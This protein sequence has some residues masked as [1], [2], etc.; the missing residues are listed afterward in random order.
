MKTRGSKRTRSVMGMFIAVV[1][2]VLTVEGSME[3]FIVAEAAEYGSG[4]VNLAEGKSG[5]ASS[6]Q[7][8][9]STVG[10]RKV[11]Y[12]TD[13]N[14]SSY[15]ILH[16]EDTDPWVYA[17]LESEYSVNKV[18]VYQ[19]ADS[20]YPN[21]YA[22]AFT[23]E[24]SSDLNGSWKTAAEYTQGTAGKNT[25]TFDPVTARYIRIRVKEKFADYASFLELMVYETDESS[26]PEE[27]TDPM[28]ILFIGN[29][30]TYYNDVAGKVKDL[31]AADGQEIETETLI[32]LGKSLTYHSTLPETE[33]TIL[34]GDFDYVVL[35]D[36]ASNFDGS[37][38][39]TGAEAI[40]QWIAQADAKTVFY[41]PW[42][43]EN[44]LE[45]TQS[46]FTESYITAAKSLGAQLAPAGEVWYEFYFDYGYNW[47]SDN[48]H[49]NN[50]GSLVSA[51][52]IFYTITGKT[53]PLT[54][55]SADN[56]V[57]KNNVDAALMNLIQQRC[58]SYAA[59]YQDLDNIQDPGEKPQLPES[60]QGT[61]P[62]IEASPE[63]NPYMQRVSAK[64]AVTASSEKQ[65]AA[66]AI[67]GNTNSR[68][69][70]AFTDD[71]WICLDLGT[72]YEI[73]EVTIQWETAAGKVYDIQISEDGANWTTVYTVADGT[74]GAYL[75]AVL[76]QAVSGRYVRIVGKER[77]TDYGYSIYELEVYASVGDDYFTGQNLAL[78]KETGASSG[79]GALAV[80]GKES[81]RW[82]SAFRNNEYLYVD[83]GAEYRIDCVNL[84][85]EAAYGKEYTIEA[86][87]D[88]TDW[89][90]VYTES[91][92]EGGTDAI[93][94]SDVTARYVMVYGTKRGTAYGF[95]LWEFEIYGG[96]KDASV[97]PGKPEIAEP[98][99]VTGV[100]AELVNGAVQLLWEDAGALQY[101]VSR[102]D[103]RSGYINLTYSA[104]ADGYL[105]TTVTC[106]GLYYYR[107]TGYF[108]DE[109]GN[110]ISGEISESAAICTAEKLPDKISN[111]TSSV[112][113]KNVVLN[114]DASDG[115]Q[116]YKISRASGTTGTYYTLKYG[117]IDTAYTDMTVS[118]GRYRY[119]VVAYYKDVDGSFVYG[120]LS[121][122]LYVTVK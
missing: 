109:E 66:N 74:G 120:E 62:S 22:T 64:A 35:Q 52:T 97:Q 48:I 87:A 41:M 57:S 118:A 83:L 34:N 108:R 110:L 30:L 9:D 59:A 115:A 3:N 6:N 53:I 84:I 90:T 32:Q 72:V 88:G 27:E 29:S 18:V 10:E 111:L 2:M 94:L 85:W 113:G 121:D 56:I 96:L 21:A 24:Y 5:Y 28:R 116:Y 71:E 65:S 61:K 26:A 114:W 4:T 23:V 67:D 77:T 106:P 95:S 60:E 13:G 81:T 112:T 86:S 51:A 117:V 45:T 104:G 122:T 105:D 73:S 19:G 78:G 54:F 7:R 11:N 1:M 47:Y 40:Y 43:N 33:S 79:N 16:K 14:T 103:G 12:L 50:T 82:E 15:I 101:K 91:E 20:T 58:C 46:Y 99:K 102:S 31:F 49:A 37:G 39:Q 119:K 38:L 63:E 107:I 42:A 92:G 93:T 76:N 44:V 8:G 100:T 75:D 55:E 17:D 36:K 98:V 69:E 80:D 25:V 89:Q 70:S 68:W